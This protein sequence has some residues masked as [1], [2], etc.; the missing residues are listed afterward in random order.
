MGCLSLAGG[1]PKKQSTFLTSII[2]Q[3][4][5]AY[6]GKTKVW[7]LDNID[8]LLQPLEKLSN[9]EKYSLTAAGMPEVIAEM[10]QEAKARMAM[11]EIGDLEGFANAELLVLV[12]NN[13]N[14]ADVMNTNKAALM[15]Y[16]EL[17]SK[18][19]DMGICTFVTNVPNAGYIPS[20]FYKRSIEN[21][22]FLW[23][24]NLSALKI[25]SVPYTVSKK[26]NKKLEE[27]DVYL[28][29]DTECTKIKTPMES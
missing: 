3:M 18:Y 7:I 1:D 24:D 16:T 11:L 23:F 13:P 15:A 29:N 4:N 6:S 25:V 9:V 21:K 10:E 26:Y 8:R 19:K 28:F 17:I 2:Q 27:G 20:E 22:Q 5:S 12:I 14:I